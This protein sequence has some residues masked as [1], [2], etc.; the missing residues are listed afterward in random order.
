MLLFVFLQVQRNC[1]MTLGSA[2]I[3]DCVV[4][5]VIS[6]WG[7]FSLFFPLSS[8]LMDDLIIS[9]YNSSVLGVLS[10]PEPAGLL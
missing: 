10:G 1:L 7:I 9:G 6:G 4:S 2:V 5:I 3:L 8:M